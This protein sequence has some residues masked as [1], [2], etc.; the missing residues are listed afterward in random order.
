MANMTQQQM[1]ARVAARF[2]RS[3][4]EG[5][6]QAQGQQE[7]QP[8]EQQPQEQQAM[9]TSGPG[10]AMV[11]SVLDKV[12]SAFEAGDEDGFHKELDSLLKA[13]KH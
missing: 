8:Q 7:Q 13:S 4:Q 2:I 6:Q 12:V 3:Q 9:P 11:K 1:S 10:K 5:P